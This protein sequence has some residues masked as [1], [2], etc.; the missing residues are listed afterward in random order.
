MAARKAHSS[1]LDRVMASSLSRGLMLGGLL[2]LWAFLLLGRLYQLQIIDY[3][4]LV[5]QANREQDRTIEVAPQR[6]TIY[7]RRMNPLAMSLAV[8]S[9]YAVPTEIPNPKLAATLLAQAL[10]LD[11]ADL[12]G[13]FKTFKSFCWIERKVSSDESA[14][15]HA[16]DLKGIYFQKE[17]KRFY[18][19]G[20]LAAQV[21]GYVGLDDQGLGGIEY[22]MNSEIQGRP[23]KVLIAE[24][25]RRQSFR[26]SDWKGV[27]GKNVVLTLDENIQYIA[28][29]ALAETVRH[30]HAAGG[31][32]IVENPNNGEIL[33]LA[34]QP[35]FNPNDYSKSRPDARIDRA[36]GWIYEPG[37]TFKL[38][39]LS[40]ALDLGLAHPDEYVDCQMGEIVLG[41]RTIHDDIGAIRHERDGP[42][43]LRQVLAYSSDVGSV[44]M[45]LRL[46]EDRFYNEILNFG[47]D[48]KTD[49]GLPGEERGL[50]EPPRDWSGVSIGELAIGQ[51]VG[52]TPIQLVSAY[53]AVANDGIRLQPR[54]VREVFSSAG[55]EPTPLPLGRRIISPQT[56]SEMKQMLAGVVD[57]G[58]GVTAQ[59]S[60][61]IAAGKTGTAQKVDAS[62]RYSHTHY[63]ASFVG[64]AP[65][66]KPAIT[67]L[68]VIDTP[69]GAIYGTEVAAPAFR[70]I[71]EQTLDY[72][73]VPQDNPSRWLQTASTM[74]VMPRRQKRWDATGSR[75]PD[76]E[77]TG[78][79]TPQIQLA[80]F[81]STKRDEPYL[82]SERPLTSVPDFSG[83]AARQVAEQCQRLNLNLNLA[84]SGLAIRQNPAAGSQVAAGTT[85]WVQFGR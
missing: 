56:A 28:E 84:G 37:S 25:A 29:K 8:D 57:H 76:S 21:L 4:D 41:G 14:R 18:P 40:G 46:G 81:Q 26:S 13:R 50:L 51:G 67:V 69:V 80:A 7:D 83:L 75:Q 66:E 53:S 71:A 62:G 15:V 47:F 36:I 6:G 54:I 68:V 73:N 24:D 48:A 45:A 49:L 5:G 58:T 19:K 20:T 64:F 42:L 55:Q 9:I 82:L 31:T 10:N 77:H 30:W 22:G 39:T 59:L 16:L 11:P 44:K 61:Y 43:T 60:G 1:W 12:L 52:V 78:A 79:A 72:L 27:P 32:V 70:S 74:P 65:I 63:V 2:V 17:M 85:V 23:G 33:A 34:N 3:V 38:V 35:T